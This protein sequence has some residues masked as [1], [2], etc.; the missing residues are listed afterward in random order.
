MRPE[1]KQQYLDM[2]A[3]VFVR[4]LRDSLGHEEFELSEGEA[5]DL[6]FRRE[7]AAYVKGINA[8]VRILTLEA[9]GVVKAVMQEPPE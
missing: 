6:L 5:T 7:I 2:Q 3:R 9:E 1:D 8:A 4:A